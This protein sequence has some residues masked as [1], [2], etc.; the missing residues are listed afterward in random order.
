MAKVR[1]EATFDREAYAPGDWVRIIALVHGERPDRVHRGH[2]HLVNRIE[3]TARGIRLPD[4][5]LPTT[6]NDL[7]SVRWQVRVDAKR[8]GFDMGELVTLTVVPR[9]Q[10]PAPDPS[11]HTS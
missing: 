6:R 8:V 7:Y 3:L 10:E 4:D 1:V 11:F 2:A 9:G 5:A